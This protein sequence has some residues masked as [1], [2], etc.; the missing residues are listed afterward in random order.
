MADLIEEKTHRFFFFGAGL[1]ICNIKEPFSLRGSSSEPEITA[2]DL[3]IFSVFP[4]MV[5]NW[6]HSRI[7]GQK[8]ECS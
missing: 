1:T 7:T 4:S 5:C 8:Y 3:S 2:K 6:Y